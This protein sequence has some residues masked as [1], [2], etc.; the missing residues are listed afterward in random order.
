MDGLL[1]ALGSSTLEE[2][3]RLQDGATI[4]EIPSGG[5]GS[6][7]IA[8]PIIIT[9]SAGPT[10]PLDRSFTVFG[11]RHTVDSHTFVNVTADLEVKAAGVVRSTE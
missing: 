10:L 6:Q 11:Q 5:W 9:G 1:A 7:R 2:S 8:S 3:E 4:D